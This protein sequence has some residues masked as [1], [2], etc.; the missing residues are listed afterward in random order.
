MNSS[1]ATAKLLSLQTHPTKVTV[2]IIEADGT[3]SKVTGWA[4]ELL[5]LVG[6]CGPTV[7]FQIKK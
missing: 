1:T 5:P 4:I 2:T 3:K 6:S 7:K